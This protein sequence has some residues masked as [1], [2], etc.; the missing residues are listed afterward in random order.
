MAVD[1]K[2]HKALFKFLL[3]LTDF[4]QRRMWT[5]WF[6]LMKIWHWRS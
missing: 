4:K 1:Y 2:I 6:L 5:A 3:L